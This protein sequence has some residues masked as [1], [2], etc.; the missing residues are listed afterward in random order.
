MKETLVFYSQFISKNYYW[1]HNKFEKNTKKAAILY[2]INFAYKKNYLEPTYCKTFA[3]EKRTG[4]RI[5]LETTVRIL[6]GT[7][8]VL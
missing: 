6:S 3:D 7:I 5:Q 2:S 4:T 8:C 1:C